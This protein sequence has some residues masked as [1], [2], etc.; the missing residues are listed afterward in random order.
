MKDYYS[1]LGIP[2]NASAE[3]IKKAYRLLAKKYHPDVNQEN[4]EF[5]EEKFKEVSEAYDVLKD[6]AKRLKYNKKLEDY[7]N[8]SNNNYTSSNNKNNNTSYS[9][10]NS[11]NNNSNYSAKRN[12]NSYN[13]KNSNNDFSQKNNDKPKPRK[14]KSFFK[15]VAIL[16]G[17]VLVLNFVLKEDKGKEAEPTLTED[18]VTY[19]S[20]REVNDQAKNSA[21]VFI[22]VLN[23][24][25]IEYSTIP[26]RM[27]V[28][29]K[30][31]SYEKYTNKY[32]YETLYEMSSDFYKGE[33]SECFYVYYEF[34]LDQKINEDFISIFVDAVNALTEEQI[35]LE[36]I[37]EEMSKEE[38]S[39]HR[40][41]NIGAIKISQISD[42]EMKLKYERK[43]NTNIV[44][45]NNYI[46]E[47]GVITG[48]KIKTYDTV[49]EY[50][51]SVK[52]LSQD[53]KNKYGEDFNSFSYDI[54]DGVITSGKE[55]K[56]QFSQ[57]LLIRINENILNDTEDVELN[58]I[59]S[60][61]EEFCGFEITDKDLMIE[62]IKSHTV[63]T[64]FELLP[65]LVQWEDFT[66]HYV[67][68]MGEDIDIQLKN[69]RYVTTNFID[70]DIHI[71][72]IAEGIGYVNLY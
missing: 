1:I 13:T 41:I 17:I 63:K 52:L 66:P 18:I 27:V 39:L 29:N 62:F 70:V 64:E 36:Q 45:K 44:N 40:P 9:N 31:N 3:E 55:V 56:A 28:A 5:Y 38:F 21:N 47:D 69:Y 35:S 33:G 42:T 10:N 2:T 24:H 7:K 53:F 8:E 4:S 22:E 46:I 19:S 65:V 14:K 15:K 57:N 12:S 25:N 67:L 49:Q 51:D 59:I 43:F 6:E 50:L 61:I 54:S 26:S 32:M 30:N 20:Y 23:K 72:V 58:T 11:N 34:S 16:I 48:P 68:H 71:P 37:K 60:I